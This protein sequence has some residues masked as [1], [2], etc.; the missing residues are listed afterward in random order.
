MT[1]VLPA[2]EIPEVAE[3]EVRN[4]RLGSVI[5]D[6]A[7]GRVIY[8]LV[9]G[10]T[11]N[12]VLGKA[13]ETARE[14]FEGNRSQYIAG[15]L[16]AVAAVTTAAQLEHWLDHSGMA[17]EFLEGSGRHFLV[18]YLGAMATIAAT[19]A[20]T[21]KGKIAAGLTGGLI[22]DGAAELLQSLAVTGILHQGS[23]K[24]IVSFLSKKEIF[25]G[26]AKDALAAEMTAVGGIIQVI[27]RRRTP[28]PGIVQTASEVL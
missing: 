2:A 17:L 23:F 15:G 5:S 20:E 27:A 10:R 13:S 7:L 26:N 9:D 21:M 8:P 24:N 25:W 19:K 22:G 16:A 14:T 4:K 18:G 11:T 6:F 12:L 28:Q 3:D 1:E